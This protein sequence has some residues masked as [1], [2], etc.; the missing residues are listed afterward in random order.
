METEKLHM[1]LSGNMLIEKHRLL[2]KG[3][4]DFIEDYKIN[5]TQWG[6]MVLKTL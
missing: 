3:K 5:I 1:V 2:Y 4:S 6:N